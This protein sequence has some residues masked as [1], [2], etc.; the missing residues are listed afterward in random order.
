M[1]LKNRYEKLIQS[2]QTSAVLI[3]PFVDKKRAFQTATAYH[4]QKGD[5]LSDKNL[6]FVANQGGSKTKRA[7]TT[8]GDW[9]ALRI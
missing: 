2:D 6:A 5:F 3:G 1:N 7:K 8:T 4:Q 9:R